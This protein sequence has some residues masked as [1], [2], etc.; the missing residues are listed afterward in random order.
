M[1]NLVTQ[2]VAL[3]YLC[4]TGSH[5]VHIYSS[6]IILLQSGIRLKVKTLHFDDGVYILDL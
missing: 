2:S 1:E 6:V 5:L 4:D 3:S